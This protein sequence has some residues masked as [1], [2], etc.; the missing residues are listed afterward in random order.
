MNEYRISLPWTPS[1]NRYYRHNR[2][3]THISA[4][5]QAYR[6]IVASIIKEQMLDIGISA[7]VRIR[8]ECHMPDRRRRDLD[9]L[10]KAAFD[11]LTKSGFWLDDQQV[12][13]Y[14]VKRMPVVK[15]GRLELTITELEEA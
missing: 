5:G 1:N 7:A 15:G 8:I 2:G 9:N 12:D 4:E 10:Q 6:D 14:S 3:R 13:Y 11:A